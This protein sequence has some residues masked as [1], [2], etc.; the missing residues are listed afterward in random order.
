MVAPTGEPL[1]GRHL[2]LEPLREADLDELYPLLADPEVYAQGYVM[3]R[4]P[5]SV[6]DARDLVRE[7][8]LG[9]GRTAYAIRLGNDGE[10][11]PARTL[12]EARIREEPCSGHGVADRPAS[13]RAVR[14]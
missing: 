13:I 4:R 10:L 2:R 11:G 3:H 12:V 9:A 6:A 7:R 5:A 14:P 8:F 1:V